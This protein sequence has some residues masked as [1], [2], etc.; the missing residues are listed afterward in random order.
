MR[1][2]QGLPAR[3]SVILQAVQQMVQA[4]A[5]LVPPA[6][7]AQQGGDHLRALGLNMRQFSSGLRHRAAL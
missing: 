2:P 6:V 5:D 3:A 4:V 1:Q 7:V